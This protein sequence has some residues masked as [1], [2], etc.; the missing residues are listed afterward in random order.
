MFQHKGFDF[1]YFLVGLKFFLQKHQKV[2][3]ITSETEMNEKY[4]FQSNHLKAIWRASTTVLNQGMKFDA[5]R[6]T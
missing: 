4:V 5:D 3:K 2:K 1:Y 6:K